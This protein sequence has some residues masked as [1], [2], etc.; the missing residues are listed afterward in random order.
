MDVVEARA[1]LGGPTP[2]RGEADAGGHEGV[3]KAFDGPVRIGIVIRL[4]ALDH[5]EQLAARLVD[6]E[7]PGLLER[8]QTHRETFPSIIEG[9][10]GPRDAH[11]PRSRR[12]RESHQYTNNAA[13][14]TATTTTR[15][16]GRAA[17][18]C[19]FII[20]VVTTSERACSPRRVPL[21][22]LS[23]VSR[24]GWKA[25]G[26]CLGHHRL[27]ATHDVR[28]RLVLGEEVFLNLLG[29]LQYRFGVLVS[30]LR[31]FVRGKRC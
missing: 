30:V 13:T 31:P 25:L 8:S 11:R 10:V 9:N 26:F 29:L 21:T 23:S 20:D 17:P 24:G 27:E 2:S 1:D 18:R 5:F 3:L 28:N 16:A 7:P 4:E 6:L 14:G 22:G 15:A 12:R 19:T